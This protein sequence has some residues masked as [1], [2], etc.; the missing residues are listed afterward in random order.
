[1]DEDELERRFPKVDYAEHRNEIKPTG[2]TGC[3]ECE[4][5]GEPLGP[6][7][8]FSCGRCDITLS[9]AEDATWD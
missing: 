5:C 2:T 1:M 6:H 8:E 4:E 9:A 7:D 3:R